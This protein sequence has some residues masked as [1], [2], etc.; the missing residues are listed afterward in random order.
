[1]AEVVITRVTLALF[2]L[3]FVARSVT[4]VVAA[5]VG[6]PEINPVEVFNESP[7]GNPVAENEVG[8]LVAVIW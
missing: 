7:A 1:M 3:P 5:V 6:D 8:A 2:P 4:F